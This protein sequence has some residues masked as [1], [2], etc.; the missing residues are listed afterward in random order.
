MEAV[1][2]NF[3][4]AIRNYTE[5][6]LIF[7][8]K[9]EKLFISFKKELSD[10]TENINHHA[11]NVHETYSNYETM[12]YDSSVEDWKI[13]DDDMINL[14][15]INEPALYNDKICIHIFKNTECDI[16]L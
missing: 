5:E 16:C 1:R 12:L 4:K 3:I 11:N 13:F 2:S 14:D 7:L 15:F 9:R 6:E 10:I 8:H